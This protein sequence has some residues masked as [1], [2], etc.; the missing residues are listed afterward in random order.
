MAYKSINTFV[1]LTHDLVN[2]SHSLV[3][4]AF[5]VKCQKRT[6]SPNL[7]IYIT[8]MNI[9]FDPIVTYYIYNSL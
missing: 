7:H 4:D 5:H 9:K 8:M 6:F 3:I 2:L 1:L